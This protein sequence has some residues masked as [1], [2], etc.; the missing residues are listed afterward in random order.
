M[1]LQKV[2]L[3]FFGT[4]SDGRVSGVPEE[5]REEEGREGEGEEVVRKWRGR[6]EEEKGVGGGERERI[7]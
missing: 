2:H 7:E 1:A 4:G 5:G 3:G 6:R